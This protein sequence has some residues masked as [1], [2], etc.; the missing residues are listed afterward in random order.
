M[1]LKEVQ[2]KVLIVEDSEA[3]IMIM[4]S[5]LQME[6]YDIEVARDGE[7]ALEKVTSFRPDLILL[8]LQLPKKNGYE[9]TEQLKSDPEKRMIPIVIVTALNEMNDKIKGI[10]LG[11]D[12]YL[13]KPFNKFELLARVKSLIKFKKMNDKLESSEAIL[14]SLARAIEAK[15]KYTEGHSERVSIYATRL[16]KKIGMSD[17]EVE[18]I[19]RG[20]L[21]HDIG[22]IGIPEQ[23]LCKPAPLDYEEYEIMKKHPVIGG[24]IAEPLKNSEPIVNMIRYHHEE[25]DG[26]GHPD[27]LKGDDI[28]IEARIISIVDTYDAIITTRPYRK[29]APKTVA[30]DV[31]RKGKGQQWDPELVEAFIEM[32]EEWEAEKK[33]KRRS[34]KLQ[35]SIAE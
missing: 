20:G 35:N 15:D 31:L 9:V 34:R 18:I 5:F 17:A 14:F 27:G 8:D 22:K 13:M 32:T 2:S 30:F 4:T 11:A 33:E 28:P 6:G 29:G 12:D 10:E 1:I 7:E 25:W 21:L 26:S 16:A 3:N 24:K 23:I 19:R